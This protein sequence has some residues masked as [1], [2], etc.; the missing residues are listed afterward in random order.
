MLRIQCPDCEAGL[1]IDESKRGR[2]VRCPKCQHRFTVPA[3][4]PVLEDEDD[5]EVELLVVEKPKKK[6]PNPVPPPLP[7]DDVEEVDLHVVER[8]SEKRPK[9]YDLGDDEEEP[10]KRRRPR[11]DPRDREDPDR[12][13]IRRRGRGKRQ[14]TGFVGFLQAEWNLDKIVVVL[15]VGLWLLFT[16]LAIV[17]LPFVL[18]L[19]AFG[20][21]MTGIGRIW[22]IA[23]AFSEDA[24]TGFLTLM[25]PWYGLFGIE[26]RRPIFL[27]CVGVLYILT[28]IGIVAVYNV[29]GRLGV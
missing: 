24:T 29:T 14:A 25:F 22:A 10:P 12:P 3:P 13:R 17:F 15:A 8:P 5:E 9:A 7:E 21:L 20:F 18:G 2:P 19:F 28:G 16:G 4:P 27:T 1:R 26:D 11:Y 23:A 6:R